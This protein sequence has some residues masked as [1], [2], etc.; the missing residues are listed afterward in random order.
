M[1]LTMILMIALVIYMVY[2]NLTLGKKAKKSRDLSRSL[3]NFYDKEQLFPDLENCIEAEKDPLYVTKY[4]I[5]QA[6]AA[7][8]YDEEAIYRDALE[9]ID[10]PIL[11]T[12]GK[13][14]TIS[15]N[16]D[17]FFYLY[18]AIPNRLY[19]TGRKDLMELL[20]Q[21]MAEFDDELNS[22]MVWVLGKAV[23]KC[24]DGEGDLGRSQFENI[25]NG[26][27]EGLSY[28]KQ[29]IGIYKNV[30]SAMLA[31]IAKKNNDQELY[32]EQIPYLEAFSRTNLGERW[33]EE[34]GI[35]LEKEDDEEPDEFDEPEEPEETAEPEESDIS[36]EE[37]K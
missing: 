34:I 10:V 37:I 27:Y 24:Y 23:R 36:E 11:I 17:S 35:R 15:E 26:E 21:K 5:I 14:I 9:K 1:N 30:C 18:L 3:A 32:D 12:D 7:A 13:K 20:D 8:Y 25:N 16:E 31:A 6:W 19:Y 28:T 22:Y 29:L 33:L 2:M 4:R